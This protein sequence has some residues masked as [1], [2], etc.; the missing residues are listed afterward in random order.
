VYHVNVTGFGRVTP[1]L[2]DYSYRSST[3]GEKSCVGQVSCAFGEYE[4]V[5]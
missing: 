5:C 1:F 3:I 4:E 2:M